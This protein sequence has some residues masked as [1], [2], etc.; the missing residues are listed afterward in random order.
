MSSN[1]LSEKLNLTTKLA[2]GAG[3]IGPALTAN[4]LVFFLMP[5]FTNV[6]GLSPGVAGSI[7]FV[8]KLPMLLMIL[9]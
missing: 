1:Q 3:D 6:A 7:L 4:I 2:F 9:S 5:F 8:G